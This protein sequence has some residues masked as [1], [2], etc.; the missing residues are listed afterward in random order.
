M[1]EKR[2]VII[3][4]VGAIIALAFAVVAAVISLITGLNAFTRIVFPLLILGVGLPYAIY[5]L[6]K[7][8]RSPRALLGYSITYHILSIAAEFMGYV[9]LLVTGIIGALIS[10]GN[11]S[12]SSVSSGTSISSSAGGT[13]ASSTNAAWTCLTLYLIFAVVL[14]LFGIVKIVMAYEYMKDHRKYHTAY[15]TCVGIY[16]SLMALVALLVF[17]A[18]ALLNFILLGVLVIAIGL[19]FVSLFVAADTVF[20]STNEMKVTME[21][22]VEPK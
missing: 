3:C 6:V 5:L 12:S 20:L 13:T 8:N 4:R 2:S 14:A 15:L 11:S 9:V 19:M 17:V 10:H 7:T 16:W 1:D 18:L 21:N 22:G